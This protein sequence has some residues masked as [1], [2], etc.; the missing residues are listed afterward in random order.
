[1]SRLWNCDSDTELL[2][3]I[4]S[5]RLLRPVKQWALAMSGSMVIPKPVL[6]S[7]TTWWHN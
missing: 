7:P 4:E 3:R 6:I 2:R 5:A 1:M